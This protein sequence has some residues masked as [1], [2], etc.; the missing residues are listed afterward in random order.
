LA[1]SA[2]AIT[3]SSIPSSDPSIFWQSAKAH[4]IF[5]PKEGETVLEAME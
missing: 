5:H 1:S 3:P 4:A 2:S